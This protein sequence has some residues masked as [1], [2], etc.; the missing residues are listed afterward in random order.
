MT[1]GSLLAADLVIAVLAAAA[2]LGGGAAAAARLATQS[3]AAPAERDDTDRVTARLRAELGPERFD[4][5]L[6]EGAQLSPGEARAQ[7]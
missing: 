1:T 3:P 7:L 5:L 4:A 2:W 6:A